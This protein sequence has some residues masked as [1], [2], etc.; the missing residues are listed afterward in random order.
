M[1]GTLISIFVGA[2][3]GVLLTVGTSV[4]ASRSTANRTASAAS[5]VADPSRREAG[6][7]THPTERPTTP[8]D[9][10]QLAN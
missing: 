8:D 7:A 5:S 10:A 4:H 1:K 2:L 3:A 9:Q 6:A